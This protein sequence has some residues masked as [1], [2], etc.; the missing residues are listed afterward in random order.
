MNKQLRLPGIVF[1][2]VFLVGY[3]LNAIIIDDNKVG[4]IQGLYTPTQLS[5]IVAAGLFFL[6]ASKSPLRWIQP[7]IF[8][9]LAPIPIIQQPENIYGLGFYIMGILLTERAGFFLKHRAIKIFVMIG[10]LLMIE[11][12]A[13]IVLNTKNPIQDVLAPTFYIIAFGLFLWV[14]Y[15]NQLVVIMR[16]P[17]PKLSLTE[18]G[19]SPAERTFVLE[20]LKGKS[21]KEIAVDFDLSESTI[22]N[23]LARSYKKLGV[24]DRVGLAVLGERFEVVE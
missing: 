18:K 13:V 19:I 11:I 5:L 4:F 22:R 21:Q 6:S 12:V 24:E 8:L 9:L 1:G 15:R 7:A 10:Y 3:L 23:T 16:E 17:R 20:T 2:C 14:L